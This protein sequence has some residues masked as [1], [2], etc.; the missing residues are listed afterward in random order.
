MANILFNSS[1]V[2]LL[3]SGKSYL[4]ATTGVPADRP[5]TTASPKPSGSDLDKTRV[6]N[7]EIASWGPN[8]DWPKKAD[9]IIG[10][11]GTLNTGLRF[12][13]NFTLGQGI[14][15]CTVTGYDEKG[16]EQMAAPKDKT[17]AIFANN[18]M[19]RRYMEKAIRDY[20][21]LGIAYVQF[22]FNEEGSLIV[23]INAINAKYCRLTVAGKDGLIEKCIVS[24]RWPDNQIGRAHV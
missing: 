8:N 10:K 22:L 4:G 6:G 16:N 13:R 3:A 12:T 15:P 1:G 21:K 9:E 18:R 17:L 14:F 11:V 19:V 5:K 2:P 23:G 24:G 7:L 20:L